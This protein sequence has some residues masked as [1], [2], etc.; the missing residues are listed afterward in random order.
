MTGP[1]RIICLTEETTELL[2]LLGEQDRIVGISAY[3]VRPVRARTEKPIVSAF[4]NGSIPKI[5]SL[6]PDLVI[7][8]SDIQA[9]L[10]QSLIAEGLNVLVFN[11][12]SIDEI[13]DVMSWVGSL[14]GRQAETRAL[15]DQFRATLES[16][17]NKN[18]RTDRPRVLFQEWDD[19]IITGIRWVSELIEIAGGTDIFAELKMGAMA[20]DRITTLTEIAKRRPE[21]II[22]SWC[23]KPV[24]LGWIYG[25]E[26]WKDV[27]ALRHRRVFEI[28]SSIILQPGPALFL[29]GLAALQ[30]AIHGKSDNAD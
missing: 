20:R 27:P 26:E 17:T 10:A 3:T 15:L 24:D 4:L 13:F 2:Y 21:V 11:Q 25:Q 6:K 18:K 5:K 8:F 12:R 9:D 22:G 16:A 19:P 14:V 30:T 29:E 28:D 7:G 1:R 23:G